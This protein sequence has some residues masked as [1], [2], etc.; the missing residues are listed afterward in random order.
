MT[1]AEKAKIVLNADHIDFLAQILLFGSAATSTQLGGATRQI[2]KV[3]QFCR[4]NGLVTFSKNKWVLT[5]LG[6]RK[7]RQA[8][9][10]VK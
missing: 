7:L 1:P 9:G 8:R 2:D 3:R 10:R 6:K 4:K 5:S